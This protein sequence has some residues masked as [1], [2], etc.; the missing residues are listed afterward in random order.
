MKEEYQEK[1]N[2][3]WSQFFVNQLVHVI[4]NIFSI[5]KLLHS[6]YNN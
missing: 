5:I 4:N 6:Y 1:E 3:I 2:V